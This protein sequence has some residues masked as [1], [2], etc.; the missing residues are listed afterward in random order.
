MA[1][2]RT[3]TRDPLASAR[4]TKAKALPQPFVLDELSDLDPRTKPMFGCLAVYVDE[5]IVFILR[6]KVK[7][8]DNGVWVGFEAANREAIKARF[9]RLR[10]IAVFG[11]KVS[12]WLNL[13]ASDPEFEQD[14][15]DACELVKARNP[16]VGKVPGA[17]KR[18]KAPAASTPRA[19]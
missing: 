6:D 7:D 5:R 10:P 8:P 15:L 13:A 17:K 16:L 3:G 11:D 4:K 14:V 2:A 19:R 12:G 18:T 9:P 1:R